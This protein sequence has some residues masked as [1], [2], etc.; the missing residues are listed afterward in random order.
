MP[1]IIN[2]SDK[3][4]TKFDSGKKWTLGFLNFQDIKFFG[5]STN[6]C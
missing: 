6:G 5:R 2:I 1:G 3:E 4:S